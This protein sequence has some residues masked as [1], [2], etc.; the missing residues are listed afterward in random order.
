MASFPL[1][2]DFLYIGD[3]TYF[4]L[5]RMEGI[6]QAMRAGDF[7]VRLNA[8]Q[9]SGYG[10]LSAT[11]YPQLFLY[12]F[13]LMRFL[14][15]SLMLCYKCLMLLINMAGA[16][17]MYYSVK[18]ICNSC[19][20]GM[21][22]SVLYTF[23]S[24]R[25]ID[26]YMRN[27]LGETLAM[28][29]FP[30]VIW[31]TY[32]ILW[33]DSRK[34]YILALGMT[35]ILQ[36]HVLST[37]MCAI[38][39]VI[40]LVVWLAAGSKKDM[41][42]RVFDGVKAVGFTASLNMGFL[43]PFLYFG[44]QDLQCFHMENYLDELPIYFTQMFSLFMPVVGISA[45]TGSTKGEIALSVGVVLLLG[46]ILFCINQIRN[47]TG[48]RTTKIG[49]RCM[50]YG[51]LALLFS[52]W[53]FPWKELLEMEWFRRISSPLQFPWRFLSIATVFLCI[54]SAIAIENISQDKILKY[55]YK[56]LAAGLTICSTCY[57]FDMLC[58]QSDSEG[59]KMQLEGNGFSDSMYLYYVTDTY[60]AWHLYVSR[61]NAV[62]KCAGD[63][64]VSFSDYWK[65]GTN[66]EV[67][68]NNIKGM[69]DILVFPLFYYPGYEILINGE[70]VEAMYYANP[71]RF[72]ACEL[73]EGTAHITVSYKGLPVF[74]AGDMI[75][76]V[77]II[78]SLAYCIKKYC[79]VK[80]HK[81]L[82]E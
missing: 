69:E 3:D 44:R 70:R 57:C 27:A 71:Q 23:S 17:T 73:P 43:I 40:E 51:I 28:T 75:S 9:N 20:I 76:L 46:T 14:R 47:K 78:V 55:G 65:Q 33:R 38:F 31:G 60:E 54:V 66:I 7:P 18:N 6:Y 21:W 77:T 26:V 12:P 68:T 34:W 56:F 36:S 42:K 19:K 10:D 39:M 30:L 74:H 45:S 35:G 81:V 62:I 16:L 8:V 22:A 80:R 41:W 64:E 5:A 79:F 53:L 52:S 1:F 4:H 63:A 11:M 32:E 58:Q 50:I 25:L 13:A 37:Q 24:Y 67:T 82:E 49:S 61:E 15:I 59:N 48:D 2:S 29:F 72:L